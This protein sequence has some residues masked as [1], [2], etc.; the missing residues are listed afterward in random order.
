MVKAAVIEVPGR[1]VLKEVDIPKVPS[2]SVLIKVE[3]CAICGSDLRILSGKDRRA[4][5]PMIIGHEIAG[6]I[7][8]RGSKVDNF[9]E[10]DRVTVAPGVSCG[11][12][13]I[14]KRGFPNLCEN[15]IS[16]GYFHPGGFAQYMVPP[17]RALTQGFVNKIPE[18]LSFEEATIAEPLACCINGQKNVMVNEED[19]VVVIG[20]GP[21]GCMHVELCKSK[22][23]RK[24][25]LIQRSPFR[26]NLAKNRFHADV[27]INSS[28]EDA[29]AK[30]MSETGG[31][32]A[33]VIIVAAPSAKAQS[34][35]I[36][37]IAKR[38]RINFFGGLVHGNSQVTI[39]ANIIHYR[40][41]FI[42]GASSSTGEQNRKALKILSTGKI[43]ASDFITHVFPLAKITEAFETA[44]SKRGLRIVIKPWE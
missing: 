26:L 25:I 5:F 28:Q 13:W 24:V 16:I 19:I 9:E 40:E 35:A 15:M 36:Q 11:K 38:G 10:G 3:V 29:V 22:G 31:R 14:C 17:P 23:C 30:V 12:C 37:M 8:K 33:D 32:G 27:Y 21:I 42:S 4:K 43:K 2:D 20:A 44:K 34:E 18:N 39:D 7:V 1:I 6:I 41:C